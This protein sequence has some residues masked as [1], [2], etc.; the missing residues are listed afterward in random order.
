[1]QIS[2][3]RGEG[4]TAVTRGGSPYSSHMSGSHSAGAEQRKPGTEGCGVTPLLRDPNPARVL[5]EGWQVRA[6][7]GSHESGGVAPT[8]MG[9]WEP[10]SSS[11]L[12]TGGSGRGF[13]EQVRLSWALDGAC[14][15]LRVRIRVRDGCLG[16]RAECGFPGEQSRAGWGG[17]GR[18]G[19][20]GR[21][22]EGA[23]A[24]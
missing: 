19:S 18:S 2:T 12:V 21:Q 23:C 4:C 13:P 10:R 20:L 8:C 6:G 24:R 15:K 17:E 11:T 5:T 9:I 7:F 1:M 16:L 22:A 3:W 14:V